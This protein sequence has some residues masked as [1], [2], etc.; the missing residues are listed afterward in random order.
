MVFVATACNK[1]TR[2]AT[3][4]LKI[5]PSA[6]SVP[7][8]IAIPVATATP[9]APTP[10]P[11]P[12]PTPTPTPA[13]VK[14]LKVET[15]AGPVTLNVYS[16]QAPQNQKLFGALSISQE[17]LNHTADLSGNPVPNDS[18]SALPGTFPVYVDSVSAEGVFLDVYPDADLIQK[19]VS[20]VLSDTHSAFK[21]PKTVC[22]HYH[23]QDV[24][25]LGQTI[26][27]PGLTCAYSDTGAQSCF[28]DLTKQGFL[29][30]PD[31]GH[32]ELSCDQTTVIYPTPLIQTVEDFVKMKSM[33][34]QVFSGNHDFL[35]PL[36]DRDEDPYLPVKKVHLVEDQITF[37]L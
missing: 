26:Q 10:T 1:S 20:P 37:D 25:F 19:I 28:G 6:L 30:N 11:T 22:T 33:S 31:D 35:I 12:V 27:V 3:S 21:V 29:N 15:S 36:A 13:P 14:S 9:V 7:S 24:M 8:A 2:V 18:T 5:N 16:F 4:S 17:I 32:P 34:V 23:T